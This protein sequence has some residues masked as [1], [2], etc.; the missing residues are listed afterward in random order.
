MIVAGGVGAVILKPAGMA[1]YERSSVEPYGGRPIHILAVWQ[2]L[3]GC[4]PERQIIDGDFHRHAGR[5]G[6]GFGGDLRVGS[7]DLIDSGI[8]V[9]SQAWQAV[10]ALGDVIHQLAGS[11]MR[12]RRGWHASWGREGSWCSREGNQSARALRQTSRK[13]NNKHERKKHP[14]K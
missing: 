14:V 12:T 1:G 11:V 10:T 8:K 6:G 4:A 5:H 13:H 9:G 7:A 3:D 2:D